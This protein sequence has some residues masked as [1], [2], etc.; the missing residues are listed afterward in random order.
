VKFGSQ[1]FT[2][3][4]H[5]APEGAFVSAS[6]WVLTNPIVG[7]DT[8]T[9]TFDFAQTGVVAGATSWS[10]VDQSSPLRNGISANGSSTA[11]SVTV[12]SAVGDVVID[13]LAAD[14]N[15]TATDDG[16]SSTERWNATAGTAVTG[17]GSSETG[18][19]SVVASWTLSTTG[20]W[21]VL[22]AS[23]QPGALGSASADLN[24]IQLNNDGSPRTTLGRDRGAVSSTYEH[25]QGEVRFD[26]RMQA[27]Y[28]RIET[29][30]F[31][32][33]TSLQ[34][35]IHRDGGTADSIGSAIT[36]DDFHQI[37]F[38]VGTTDLLRRGR[39]RLTLDTNSSYAPTVSD[40]RILRAVLGIRSPDTYRA[41]M[42]TGS[43]IDSARTERKILRQR[44]GGGTVQITEAWSGTQFRADVVSIRDLETR[45]GDGNKMIYRTEI[46]F[47][48]HDVE[49]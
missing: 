39:L 23:L 42:R 43:S 14:S 28:I 36:S 12:T 17:A 34:A 21:A 22:G 46:L 16:G 45:R 19:A 32:S 7:T 33:T 30:N 3:F 15:P 38:T 5:Y 1:S 41:I 25:Y 31:D 8:I 2:K 4:I 26:R 40:P 37:D 24:Y 20:P 18:A 10:G 11:P 6:M 49:V 35:K 44:K 9:A 48:R 47:L 13:V 29:E 27:R